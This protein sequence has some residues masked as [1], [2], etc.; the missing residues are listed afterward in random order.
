VQQYITHGRPRGIDPQAARRGDADIPTLVRSIYIRARSAARAGSGAVGAGASGASPPAAVAT[1]GRALDRWA[2]SPIVKPCGPN[3]PGDLELGPCRSACVLLIATAH[4][5]PEEDHAHS[6]LI[7]PPL[8][9]APVPGQR[10]WEEYIYLRPRRRRSKFPANG[11]H[12][13]TSDSISQN[14]FP[15]MGHSPEDDHVRYKLTVVRSDQAA[16]TWLEFPHEAG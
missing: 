10:P 3:G 5:D 13:S 16:P 15:L 4:H 6:C 8:C 1:D 9:A 2:F 12:E 7:V 14:V 11:G